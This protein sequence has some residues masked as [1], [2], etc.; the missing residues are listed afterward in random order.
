MRRTLTSILLAAA[1]ASSPA[2][3]QR[4]PNIVIVFVDDMGYADIGPFGAAGY[5]TPNLDRMAKE[6]TR[7]T[8]FYD[9]QPVCSASRASLL[10]GTYPNR[11]GI[12]GALGPN[13]SVGIG[14]AEVTIAELLKAKGYATAAFGKWHLGDRP[15]FLPTRH[16][17]DEYFGLPYSND[18][19]PNHPEAKP[20]T[21][22]PLPL[23]EGD[24]VRQFMSEQSQL[25]RLYTERAVSFIER[26][27]KRPFFLYVPHTMVHV[28][29]F[30]G[31]RFRGASAGGLYGD[32]VQ[33]LDWSVGE[34]LKTIKRNGLDTNTLV[35][36]T[37]DNG[38]WLS[39]GDHAGSAGRLREGK[40]TVWEGGVRVPFLARWPGRIA[41]G[42]T[43]S[44]PAMTIDMLPTIATLVGAPLPTHTID[45]L[46]V[47]PLLKGDARAKSPHEAF[48]FYYNTNELQ[49]VRSGRWKLILPHSYRSLGDQPR[50]TGGIPAKYHNVAVGLELYDL[51]RDVGEHT[52]VAAKHPDVVKRMMVL[53]EKA[54]ADM[55]DALTKRVGHGVRE[56]GRVPGK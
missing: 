30:V 47:W 28:P 10:T 42:R 22:P 5:A 32:V 46:D 18:M 26:N 54:R 40:G 44:E 34:I 56:P 4:M 11:I 24:T 53:A 52:D 12:H 49:A 16:G 31:E 39:Y 29:L 33:E 50:A 2:A 21:Y 48:Y 1:A 7:L 14:D 25:T 17:F 41:A 27:A 37:S 36:F 3:A 55:G 9:A 23:L 38:P 43:T 20:G 8:S 6:G 35:I 13:S 51:E 45:G 19:W 15:Q